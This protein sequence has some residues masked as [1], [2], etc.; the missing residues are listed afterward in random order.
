MKPMSFLST[1][2]QT[3]V[4]SEFSL[5][6]FPRNFCGEVSAGECTPRRN[7]SNSAD[8]A[9]CGSL[10]QSGCEPPRTRHHRCRSGGPHFCGNGDLISSC[11]PQTNSCPH[12]QLNFGRSSQPGGHDGIDWA[13]GNGSI[14]RMGTIYD[15]LGSNDGSYGTNICLDIRF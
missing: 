3:P 7:G 13:A 11:H 1:S 2:C 12:G 5:A 6:K 14:F 9:T 10:G 8:G 15:G 4:N